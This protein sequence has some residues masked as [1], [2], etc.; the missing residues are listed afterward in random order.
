VSFGTEVDTK[1]L[2]I[3]LLGMGKIIVKPEEAYKTSVDLFI[4][5]GLGFDRKLHR[6]GRGGGFY[7]RL[8]SE[9][10][11]PKIGLAYECQVLAEVPHTSYDI[12]MTALITEEEL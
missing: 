1:K 12:P 6:L 3:R 7:D 10:T 5:P 11:V 4:V 2:I 9:V 8:L